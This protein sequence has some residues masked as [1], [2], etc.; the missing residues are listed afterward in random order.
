MLYVALASIILYTIATLYGVVLVN[1]QRNTTRVSV[2]QSSAH[3]LRLITDAIRRAD[4][5]EEPAH[6]SL[7]GELILHMADSELE[8][9]RF[10]LDSDSIVMQ[11][12]AHD[13]IAITSFNTI[14]SGLSFENLSESDESDSVRVQFEALFR[15]QVERP[16]TEFNQTYYA[17]ATTR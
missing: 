1:D 5:V 7:G 3:A 13:P 11:E 17:S 9:T 8:P 2:D 6:Q 12:G 16:E 14:V 4:F 10:F 15:V